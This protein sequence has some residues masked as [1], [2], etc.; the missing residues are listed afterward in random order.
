MSLVPKTVTVSGLLES[1]KVSSSLLKLIDECKTSVIY[2]GSSQ[3]FKILNC[4][5]LTRTWTLNQPCFRQDLQVYT[6]LPCIEKL[7]ISKTYL[8]SVHCWVILGLVPF[9][10]LQHRLPYRPLPVQCHM[11]AKFVEA[12]LWNYMGRDCNHC[13]H[14]SVLI[15]SRDDCF[16]SKHCYVPRWL[17]YRRWIG[18]GRIGPNQRILL[19]PIFRGLDYSTSNST[20][21]NPLSG[22]YWWLKSEF[23]I[24]LKTTK[25]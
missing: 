12:T 23:Q 19:H 18:H 21:T 6:G 25:L 3:R 16:N 10:V 7:F 14:W 22:P 5:I 24:S 2:I 1:P 15:Y 9:S 4:P 17:G 11:I 13:Q 20:M 8:C